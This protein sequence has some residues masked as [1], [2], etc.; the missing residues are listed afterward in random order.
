[1]D[2]F[3]FIEHYGDDEQVNHEDLLADNEAGATL[4]CAFIGVGGGGGKMA[5]GFLDIGFNK[6]L[7][8]NTTP[9]DIIRNA[10]VTSILIFFNFC[11]IKIRISIE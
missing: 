7:L 11:I 5:K 3:D 4:N 8:I 9:K 1:M 2:D 10:C 6:T